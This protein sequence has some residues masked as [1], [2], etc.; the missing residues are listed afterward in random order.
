ME[1]RN[2]SGVTSASRC[3][4][5]LGVGVCQPISTGFKTASWHTSYKVQL[6]GRRPWLR[7]VI[8]RGR[9]T[10]QPKYQNRG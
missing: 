7:H 8:F 3:C 9:F 6:S 1:R 10:G 4:V 2:M 5:D